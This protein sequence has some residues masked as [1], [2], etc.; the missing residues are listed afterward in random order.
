[1]A[2]EDLD[3]GA[4]TPTKS[5]L[6][7]QKLKAKLSAGAAGAKPAA[8][9]GKGKGKGKG[10]QAAPAGSAGSRVPATEWTKL[11]SFKPSGPPRCR[12]FNSSNGCSAGDKCKQKH[13][14]LE[15][16]GDHSWVSA[17]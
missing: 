6:K 11:C 16:G 13:I 8:Q 17:H 4:P 2:L 7:R 3:G 1:V 5:A 15:C 10:K 9:A 12:F 14:C